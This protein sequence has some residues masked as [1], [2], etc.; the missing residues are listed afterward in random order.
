MCRLRKHLEP[1]DLRTTPCQRHR[2]GCAP[3]AA[4]ARHG[5]GSLGRLRRAVATPQVDASRRICRCRCAE[6]NCDRRERA[7]VGIG[8]RAFGS[9]ADL[10]APGPPAIYGTPPVAWLYLEA[11]E[12]RASPRG[13]RE[14]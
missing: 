11:C 5:I 4:V 8:N 12:G 9:N 3:F 6:G 10:I 13:A 1:T 7:V 2:P 14:R